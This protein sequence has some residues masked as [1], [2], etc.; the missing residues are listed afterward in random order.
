MRKPMPTI[1]PRILRVCLA[2]CLALA[3]AVPCG[4]FAGEPQP[5]FAKAYPACDH[6]SGL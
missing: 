1:Y 2:L 3:L 6:L 5:G 4:A